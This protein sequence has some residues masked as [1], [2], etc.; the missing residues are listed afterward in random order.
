MNEQYKQTNKNSLTQTTEL[1]LPQGR[2][3][4]EVKGRGGQIYGNKRRFD[5]GWWAHNAIYR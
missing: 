2:G 3:W 5:C 4:G 1:W